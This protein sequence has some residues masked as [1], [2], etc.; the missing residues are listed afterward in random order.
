LALAA[1]RPRALYDLFDD[2][3]LK[4]ILL[5]AL[6]RVRSS[7]LADPSCV[8]T[9]RK[10]QMETVEHSIRFPGLEKGRLARNP[11]DRFACP[12]LNVARVFA[13]EPKVTDNDKAVSSLEVSWG[14][15]PHRL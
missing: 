8:R 9:S 10:V 13:H 3:L 2:R 11:A 4:L 6:T 7:S 15:S 14:D 12:F 1:K 5:N